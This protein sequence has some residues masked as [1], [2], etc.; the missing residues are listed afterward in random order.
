MAKLL[1]LV[2]LGKNFDAVVYGWQRG[3]FIAHQLVGWVL[4]S[5]YSGRP[6]E[7]NK[8]KGFQGSSVVAG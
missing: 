3:Y 8:V 5:L 1:H 6:G 2:N 7:L 4:A